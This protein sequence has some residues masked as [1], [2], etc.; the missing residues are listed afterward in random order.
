MIPLDFKQ[1]VTQSIQADWL[2]A[3]KGSLDILRIDLLHPIISGNKWF[4]LQHYLQEATELNYSTIA[5]FG[6]AYSNHII[7][8]AFACQQLGLKSVGI[9]RGEAADNLSHTLLLA[10]ELGMELIFVSREEYRD[11][12]A[13][14]KQLADNWY[15]VN[16]GGYGIKG[17]KG[18]A[19]V[20]N[21][22][23][24]LADYNFIIAA[25]GT[26]TMLAGIINA[27]LPHQ[28]VI[29]ISAMKGNHSL[30]ANVREMIDDEK[31][32][33]FSILHDYHFGGYGKHPKQLL[34]FINRSFDDYK[35]PLDIVYTSKTFFAVEDLVNKNFFPLGSKVLMIHSGGLQGNLSLP[36]GVLSF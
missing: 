32:N 24:N 6:G 2:T 27:A 18:A 20:L 10:Q 26:G 31:K 21:Y 19:A 29:G 15:W 17:A 4:K 14:Q 12:D 11:K 28:K 8:T 5:T 7:A 13:L 35:I 34:D 16:E 23:T 22:A 3:K 9:I 36:A 30:E 25:V 1:I 33:S